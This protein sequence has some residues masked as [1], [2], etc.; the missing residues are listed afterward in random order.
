MSQTQKF[1][2]IITR[3]NKRDVM[4]LAWEAAGKLLEANDSIYVEVR[5]KTRTLEQN[6]KLHA[7]RRGHGPQ[8]VE[9]GR[10]GM[11]IGK[12][13]QRIA[14]GQT[15]RQALRFLQAADIRFANQNR[16]RA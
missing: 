3:Q 16:R 4:T 1:T 7:T 9:N 2:R 5:E 13:G 8:P 14:I 15:L 11:A 12:T 6:A 10:Q